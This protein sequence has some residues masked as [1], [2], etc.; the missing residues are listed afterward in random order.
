MANT[1]T[2]KT[3]AAIMKAAWT[4]VRQDGRNLADA[5]RRAW[6]WMKRK[7]GLIAVAAPVAKATKK[8]SGAG[9]AKPIPVHTSNGNRVVW[10]IG[11]GSYRSRGHMGWIGR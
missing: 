5:M 9:W 7:L 4:I 10:N 6:A 2:N 3:R 8:D 11:G 1:I